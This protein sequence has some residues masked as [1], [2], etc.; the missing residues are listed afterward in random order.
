LDRDGTIN[1]MVYDPEFG[2]VDSPQNA[3]QFQLLPGVPEAVR[4]INELGFLAIVVSNQPGIAKGKCTSGGLE[5]ITQKMH[6]ELSRAGAH[7]DAVRYCLHHPEAALKEYRVVCNCRKP[8]PGL[9]QQAAD[10][11]AI[12]L[13]ASFMVGD[14]LTDVL[15]G[16]A[17][18]CTTILLGNHKCDTCK[19][20]EERGAR[21]DSVFPDLL[22][23][24]GFI[25]HMR[26]VEPLGG[27]KP[28]KALTPAR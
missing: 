20:M 1:G 9:L 10:E 13:R 25:S 16:K 7:L 21:P 23:A 28:A 24:V 11:L 19:V 5:A 2:L 6:D 27:R 17:V 12:D 22:A 18:G 14:G 3:E 15:A 4:L 26:G 8:R